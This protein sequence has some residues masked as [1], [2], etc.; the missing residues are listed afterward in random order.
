MFELT[1]APLLEDH[2]LPLAVMGIL[3]VFVALL[4]VATFITLL[5]RIL[6][7]IGPREAPAEEPPDSQL[8]GDEE[9]SEE[10][11]V[12]IAAAVAEV[13]RRPHRIVHVRGSRPEEVGWSLEGRI[14]HHHSHKVAQRG[15]S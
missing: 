9:L 1:F 4:L 3:V 5:P 14:H 6:E 13:V 2:G 11:M 15:R 7:R 10:V 8:A 12:V